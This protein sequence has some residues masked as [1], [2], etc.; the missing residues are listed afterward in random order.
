MGHADTERDAV[1][2]RRC[3]RALDARRPS[4]KR[5][6]IEAHHR[7]MGRT[8]PSYPLA[9]RNQRAGRCRPASRRNA[10]RSLRARSR[11]GGG[12]DDALRRSVR[13]RAGFTSHLRNA[14]HHGM[15]AVGI[16][17]RR[18]PSATVRTLKSE[19]RNQKLEIRERPRLLPSFLV[20]SFWFLVYFKRLFVTFARYSFALASAAGTSTVS[21]LRS[22]IK[23]R[24]S[25][26]VATTLL[27]D[28]A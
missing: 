12:I 22:R 10:A 1:S 6:G 11:E 16:S 21:T 26:I 24:P 28:A 9:A 23:T 14:H 8:L 20:S 15:D 4:G 7:Q 3:L 25:Q 19:T 27:P 13:K 17:S 18:S 5:S 2:S